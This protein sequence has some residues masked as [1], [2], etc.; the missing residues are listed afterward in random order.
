MRELTTTLKTAQQA[1]ALN[2]L[3]KIVLTKGASTYTYEKDRI[4]PSAHDEELYSHRATIVLNNNDHALDSLNLKGYDA[5]I[6]YGVVTKAGEEYS[7]TAPLVV[8]DQLFT[9]NPNQLTC[10]LELIGMPNLMAEDQASDSYV[11]GADDTKTVKDLVDAIVGATLA[12]FST[13]VAYETVWDEGYDSLASSYR[14]RDGFRIYTSG[15]RLAAL[16]RVLDFTA[17]VPR[18]EAD[19]KLHIMKPVCE[20][21]DYDSEYSLGAGVHNFFRKAY[22]ETLVF[23]G[24]IYVK[25]YDDDDP[26]Y[27][28]V[29]QVDGYDSLPDKVKK[30]DYIQAKLESNEQAAAIAEAL[31]KKAEMGCARGDAEIRIN[32]GSE[33]FDYVK[34]TDSRQGDTR[35]GNL[36][37]IHR[38]FGPDKWV[39]TFGFGNWLEMLRYQAVLKGLETYT[40]IDNYFS[41][42]RVGSLYA[43]LDDI[44]DGPDLYIRQRS[45]HLDATGVYVSDNTLYAIRLPGEQEHNLWKADS[46]PTNP[47]TGDF[48]I[49]TNYEPNVVKIWDG[50]SWE[51]ATT[52]QLGEF[53]RGTI[54]RRLKSSALTADG[55]V[56]LDE[57]QEGTYGLTK[58]TQ[59]QAG[60]ILLSKTVK[61]G[62][63]YNESGVA[64]DATVGIGLYGGE[65]LMAFRTYPTLA[66]YLAGTN[67]QCYVGTDGKIYAGAGAVWLNSDGISVKGEF[68]TFYDLNGVKRGLVYGSAAGAMVVAGEENVILAPDSDKDIIALLTIHAAMRPNADGYGK[69]GEIGYEFYGVYAKSRLKIP[70]GTDC[71][72]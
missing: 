8:N 25:S 54:L 71:Y 44:K 40:D 28:G 55:L 20:G 50:D 60:F 11:P 42:L 46:A 27:L 49:D 18:F 7:A 24:R 3:Y 52:A 69:I 63:W 33:V 36:G 2:P 22:K 48:W 15:S 5:V 34:I 72:D 57:T 9:S 1:G 16:R 10:V 12:P 68:I 32:V 21:T 47:E 56:V 38:R 67:L 29:A 4:L 51:N 17:N 6:S 19:G 41:R 13:C 70:V 31:I 23:P 62:L 39:E 59:I 53:N 35:T 65:G 61:D 30:V 14:P 37:Y 43:Y 58:A 64:I 66:D 26:S 45:L